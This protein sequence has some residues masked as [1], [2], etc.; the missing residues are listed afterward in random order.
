MSNYRFH[1]DLGSLLNGLITLAIVLVLFNY[2]GESMLTKVILAFVAY[3]ISY[4]LVGLLLRS[5][6]VWKR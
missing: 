3:A 2:F 6:G 4:P 1:R 5:I